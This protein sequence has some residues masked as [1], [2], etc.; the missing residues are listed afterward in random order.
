M[1]TDLINMGPE[2]FQKVVFSCMSQANPGIICEHD[3]FT[4]LEEFKQRDGDV[5]IKELMR[6][7]DV[8]R[9]YLNII[10]RS[11]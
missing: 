2:A 7:N 3:V 6:M 8:P 11:D 5:F 1:I 9:D 10:D 4:L